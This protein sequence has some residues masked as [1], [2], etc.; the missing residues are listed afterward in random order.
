MQ[1]K[2][3]TSRL[4]YPLGTKNIRVKDTTKLKINGNGF[5]SPNGNSLILFQ[6]N[7][8]T[9][10]EIRALIQFRMINCENKE[11]ITELK[12]ILSNE[13]L[14]EQHLFKK[15]KE[16]NSLE[17]LIKQ[18]QEFL[19]KKHS[20]E[21]YFLTRLK[22]KAI[23]L[24]PERPGNIQ[25]IQKEILLQLLNEES[26]ISK[27]KK[28]KKIVILV[29][30]YSVH[31]AELVKKACKILNIEFIYLPTHSPHLNPIEQVWKSIKKH[32][33]NY[34]FDSIEKMQEIFEKEY[35]RIVDNESFFENW[36]KKFIV[37][38]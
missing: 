35:Y 1:N 32:M 2:D 7:T 16:E 10:E 31:R 27:L 9:Y 3:N 5:Q 22:N 17:N 11:I 37:N 14:N 29:D 15:L 23:R 26:L 36:I 38:N 33:G 19:L 20:S 6:P 24:D 18:F 25:I 13:N 28:E 21:H 8:K 34:Y 4:Y 12:N 30:N